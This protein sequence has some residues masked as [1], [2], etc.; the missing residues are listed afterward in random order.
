MK[1]FC[2]QSSKLKKILADRIIPI[3]LSDHMPSWK[4]KSAMSS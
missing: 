2:K 3:K 4:K 1:Y